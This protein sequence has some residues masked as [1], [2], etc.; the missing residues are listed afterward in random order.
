M[1]SLLVFLF[2]EWWYLWFWDLFSCL[3]LRMCCISL[4]LFIWSAWKLKSASLFHFQSIPICW[5]TAWYDCTLTYRLYCRNCLLRTE[6]DCVFFQL[7]IMHLHTYD[8]QALCCNPNPNPISACFW[9]CCKDAYMCKCGYIYIYVCVRMC[10][11]NSSPIRFSLIWAPLGAF[12]LTWKGRGE[13][14]RPR[15][16]T[17][18]PRW[19]RGTFK[20][21]IWPR[22]DQQTQLICHCNSIFT[23][24]QFQRAVWL[25]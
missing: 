17:G 8:L 1:T 24:F 19:G 7:I 15:P 25:H 22:R 2:W 10:K 11:T 13:P 14:E 9:L 18:P 5:R 16:R 21:L 3:G 20:G 4:T 6:H 23:S 12:Q